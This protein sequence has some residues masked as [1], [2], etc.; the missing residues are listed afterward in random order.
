MSN[1]QLRNVL[2]TAAVLCLAVIGFS[3]DAFS[4]SGLAQANSQAPVA[5]PPVARAKIKRISG[6]AK[7]TPKL[8]DEQKQGYALLESAEASSRGLEAP[9]R[10]YGL[11]QIA[12]AYPAKDD[13]GKKQRQLLRDAFI[14]SLE[15]HDDNE[16]KTEL[17][18]QTFRALLPLSQ[19][20]VE[21]LLSQAE[22]KVRKQTSEQMI[23]AY[24]SKKQYDKAIDLVNQVTAW[25]EFPYGSAGEL[26]NA[27]PTDMMAEKQGLLIQAVN[28]YKNHTHKRMRMGN[29]TLTSMIVRNY[30]VM[31]PKIVLSAIDDILSQA[32]NNDEN[33]HDN[34]ISIGGSGGTVSFTSDFE[35]ELFSLM[36]V[37]QRLDE[38][39][40]N[41][42][43]QENQSL[44]AKLQQF[45]QGVDSVSPPAPPQPADELT[46]EPGGKEAAGKEGPGQE[47]AGKEGTEA[48][49]KPQRVQTSVF[50]GDAATAAKMQTV[51]D[52]GN[53]TQQIVDEA[54]KDPA[55][56]LAHATTLPVTLDGF[57]VMSPRG[58]ALTAIA[59]I[60]AK[61]NPAVAKQALADLRKIVP[62]MPLNLQ[63]QSLQSAITTYIA[64]DDNDGAESAI[65]EGIKV[66]DKLLETD[67]NPDDP[68]K[69]LKAWWPSANAYRSFVES[70]TKIARQETPAL[71]K[72]IRDQDIRTIE[73][74][75][76]ARTMLG[77]P[78]KQNRIQ[79]KRKNMNRTMVTDN[80]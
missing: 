16:T 34:N 29:G 64:M 23:R 21:E 42:L 44:Q 4:Q 30:G 52:A 27:L 78:S 26:M 65:S 36:P 17:Q 28:S 31:N 77:L 38:S 9:M 46:K 62:D 3:R 22:T 56:A 75:T 14:S 33:S 47:A 67:L 10:T 61:T 68:N 80:D 20:D 45:P 73:T 59:K 74:I 39:R 70:Q 71:L 1:A 76:Y 32:K 2:L 50:S 8:T 7:L 79:E 6:I 40:A 15:I 13:Q 37:L 72:E 60:A 11:L 58:N 35:F 19:D 43:L 51:Q 63:A 66:A 48:K 53:R 25:D 54:G 12:T 41:S 24:V 57:M 5:Q 55:Q 49:K 69:A 18:T